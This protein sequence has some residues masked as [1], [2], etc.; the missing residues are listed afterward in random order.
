MI[1]SLTIENLG[2]Y[3]GRHV[4]EMQPGA[5]Y[6]EGAN[7]SGKT[8]LIDAVTF[9]LTGKDSGGANV[10]SD[11][12]HTGM[13]AARVEIITFPKGTLF[14]RS[15]DQKDSVRRYVKKAE[16]LEPRTV[17]TEK[18]FKETAKV[19]NTALLL[20][21][22]APRFALKVLGDGN[23]K[24][25]QDLMDSVLHG[26]GSLEIETKAALTKL[27]FPQENEGDAARNGWLWTLDV[28]DAEKARAEKNK[29]LADFKARLSVNRE[30]VEKLTQELAL[31]HP[32]FTEDEAGRKQFQ[33]TL[34]K[35]RAELRKCEEDLEKALKSRFWDERQI[36]HKLD[37]QG[38]DFSNMA[39]E[40][41]KKTL[42]CLCCGMTLTDRNEWEPLFNQKLA[43]AK[44]QF[45]STKSAL[46]EA[47]GK[48]NR[49]RELQIKSLQGMKTRLFTAL[50][51][52]EA[53]NMGAGQS[54]DASLVEKR[55]LQIG[56]Q[57]DASYNQTRIVEL[58]KEC[59][60]LEALVQ[61]LRI[62]PARLAQARL[63]SL[64]NIQ[65]AKIEFLQ[66]PAKGQ[67]FVRILY[68]GLEAHL[69]SDGADI[70]VDMA[71]REALRRAAGLKW[72]PIFVDRCESVAKDRLVPPAGQSIFLR[73]VETAPAVQAAPKKEDLLLKIECQTLQTQ[74][75]HL[76]DLEKRASGETELVVE[77]L[78]QTADA[79]KRLDKDSLEKT[80]KFLREPEEATA[81]AG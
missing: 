66:E 79:M 36:T 8:T 51:P 74:I 44:A 18:D 31:A 27:G 72:V 34:E 13:D 65:D 35:A 42:K 14:G 5:N 55:K 11:R 4:F 1:K 24:L 20:S 43:K 71:F 37:E 68:K 28:K 2:P 50:M 10:K 80:L 26:V 7:E 69:A 81:S 33:E 17:N 54:M 63:D 76:V 12:I 9:C 59:A 52:L 39:L 19:G 61:A 3:K 53:R 6:L 38:L 62:A 56:A 15:I 58:E 60:Y 57:Q 21:I 30:T 32:A 25:L 29:L 73:H 45:E 75:L 40:H 48:F 46:V 22:L 78:N 70:A 41:W 23:A 47:E 67:P 16:E 77:V 64:G 49:D